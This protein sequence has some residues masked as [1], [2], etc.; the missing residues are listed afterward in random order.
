M[1]TD[2]AVSLKHNKGNRG[3]VGVELCSFFNLGPRWGGWLRPHP[4]RFTPVKENR[5]PLYSRLCGSRDRCGRVRKISLPTG[6]RSPDRP[7]RSESLCRLLY[8]G[9]KHLCSLSHVIKLSDP[10][11]L[12]SFECCGDK[13][14]IKETVKKW[15]RVLRHCRNNNREK[16][17]NTGKVVGESARSLKNFS[18]TTI[19]C[20]Y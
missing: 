2:T 11:D 4:G 5:V 14:W 9:P 1:A 16:L 20:A 6:N 17:R 3:G 7:I 8:P 19:F 10:S 13:W 18:C 12:H 15:E